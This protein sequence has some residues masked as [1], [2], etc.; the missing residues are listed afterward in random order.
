VSKT[1]VATLMKLT[2]SPSRVKNLTVTRT[3]R[4]AQVEW[5]ALPETDVAAYVVEWGPTGEPPRGA[6]RVIDNAATV[7]DLAAGEEV[8]VLGINALG[9]ASWDYARA[10]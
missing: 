7:P 6:L 9:T 3:A 8:R 4:G 2:S 10:R 5:D 1:T